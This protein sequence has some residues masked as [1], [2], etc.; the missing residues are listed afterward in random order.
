MLVCVINQNKAILN[1]FIHMFEDEVIAC[2]ECSTVSIYGH[3]RDLAIDGDNTCCCGLP[4]LPWVIASLVHDVC[5]E[6]GHFITKPK[7]R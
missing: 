3:H 4:F 7:Y 6:G 2:K 1:S 5:V